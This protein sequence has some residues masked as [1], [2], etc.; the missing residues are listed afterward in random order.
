MTNLT[1]ND[2]RAGLIDWTPVEIKALMIL[3]NQGV[4]AFARS[5]HVTRYAV[6]KWLA[7]IRAPDASNI[8]QLNRLRAWAIRKDTENE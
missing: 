3:R 8:R 1:D 7:G 2:L 6:H 5:M 4:T